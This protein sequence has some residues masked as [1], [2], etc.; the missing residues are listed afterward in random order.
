MPCI[1][2]SC[3]QDF[4]DR[5]EMEKHCAE[6]GCL[7]MSKFL[8]PCYFC[9]KIFTRKDNLRDDLRCHINSERRKMMLKQKRDYKCNKCSKEYGGLTI[10]NIHLLSH[11]RKAPKSK[12]KSPAE[13]KKAKTE[14][15]PYMV[16]TVKKEPTLSQETLDIPIKTEP[17]DT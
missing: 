16:V 14:D 4:P 12:R 2:T 11:K 10:L 6:L 7:G 3:G 5:I 1:C 17:D 15:S 9:H 13:C 8:Y